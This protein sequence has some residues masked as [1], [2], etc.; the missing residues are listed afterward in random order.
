MLSTWDKKTHTSA[1]YRDGLPLSSP[2]SDEFLDL[3]SAPKSRSP[4]IN[5]V[6]AST[7]P[8]KYTCLR[9]APGQENCH[10]ISV[11]PETRIMGRNSLMSSRLFSAVVTA[12]LACLSTS[13][14]AVYRMKESCV[15]FCARSNDMRAACNACSWRW[16]ACEIIA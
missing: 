4:K 15:S 12:C 3:E 5:L 7:M 13:R 14:H 10:L 1:W 9:L 6:A 8:C 16:L 2:E 11:S